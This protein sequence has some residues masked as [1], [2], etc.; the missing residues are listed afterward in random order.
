MNFKNYFSTVYYKIMINSGFIIN[1]LY[2]GIGS[3]L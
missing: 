2:N 3:A 1:M